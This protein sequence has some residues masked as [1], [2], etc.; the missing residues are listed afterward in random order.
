MLKQLLLGVYAELFNPNYIEHPQCD[1]LIDYSVKE[2][3]LAITEERAIPVIPKTPAY[4]LGEFLPYAVTSIFK[5]IYPEAFFKDIKKEHHTATIEPNPEIV[6]IDEI[7]TNYDANSEKAKEK[8]QS[9][10]MRKN[11]SPYVPRRLE[12]GYLQK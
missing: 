3:R 11:S 9:I 6:L 2:N 5:R 12:G 8:L 1:P 10:S 7:Q 4:F